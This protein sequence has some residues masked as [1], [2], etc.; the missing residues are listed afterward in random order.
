MRPIKK[1]T[2]KYI[3]LDENITNDKI[4]KNCYI[5]VINKPIRVSSDV[6]LTIENGT[7]IY[8]LNKPV[9]ENIFIPEN[10]DITD[11]NNNTL[12]LNGSCLI[13]E[14]GSKLISKDI[15]LFSCDKNYIIQSI[16]LNCGIFFNGTRATT[17]YNIL[18]VNSFITINNSCFKN[19][20][21]YTSYLG[22]L[23]FL[24]QNNTSQEFSITSNPD[25][26]IETIITAI[27][28]N[29]ITTLG[30]KKSEFRINTIEIKNTGSNGLWT[31]YSELLINK[32][33]IIGYEGNALFV[34]GSK[35]NFIHKLTLLQNITPNF[36][37]YKGIL[38]NLEELIGNKPDIIPFPPNEY[39]LPKN[40]LISSIELEHKLKLKLYEP[41]TKLRETVSVIENLPPTN[42]SN[43]ILGTSY[44]GFIN[45]KIIFVR[46]QK[47]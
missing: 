42:F 28:L 6:T 34:R 23:A 2:K 43:N 15:Y 37:A 47:S 26:N 8:L 12:V 16:N 41:V 20:N 30:C 7:E 46:N 38:I 29:S 1:T 22:S 25:S 33:S 19:D 14:S 40:L 3:L 9:E 4:L 32:L 18:D 10:F 31:Q 5:Y 36:P 35:I 45:K 24:V 44:S 27:P 13:F 39:D 21:I 11:P 17:Q